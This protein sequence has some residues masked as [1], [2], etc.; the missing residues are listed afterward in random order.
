M[1]R[2]KHKRDGRQ[3]RPPSH[4]VGWG[5][6]GTEETQAFVD[7]KTFKRNGE[8]FC[9]ERQ[10]WDESPV[11]FECEQIVLAVLS[12]TIECENYE[13]EEVKMKTNINRWSTAVRSLYGASSLVKKSR[14]VQKG[15]GIIPPSDEQFQNALARAGGRSVRAK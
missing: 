2:K 15:N 11:P 12:D 1:L 7:L 10:I 5:H 8:A 6:R 13:E 4:E 14:V 9:E 3:A